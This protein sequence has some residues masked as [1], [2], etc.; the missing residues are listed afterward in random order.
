MGDKSWAAPICVLESN[1]IS[2]PGYDDK[3]TA[4]EFVDEESVMKAKVKLLA[5]LIKKSKNFVT[6]TGAGLS[7]AR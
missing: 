1:V 3:T 2:R 5:Q 7:T 4:A 6:Y